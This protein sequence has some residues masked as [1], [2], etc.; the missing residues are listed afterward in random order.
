MNETK[1]APTVGQTLFALT[2]GHRQKDLMLIPSVVQKVGRKY[3][4]VRIGNSFH[5][6]EFQLRDWIQVTKY[7]P[8]YQLWASEQEYAIEKEAQENF[9]FILESF[10]SGWHFAGI[11]NEVLAQI[12]AM[13]VASKK[14][15]K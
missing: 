14:D 13:I 12:K 10:R 11:P 15:S 2:V 9:N 6:V 5:E 1:P 3:F 7:T 4:S 8:D